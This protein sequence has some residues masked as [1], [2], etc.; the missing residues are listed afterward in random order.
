[1]ASVDS[2]TISGILKRRYSPDQVEN[3]Q[4]M[5]AVLWGKL[6]KGGRKITGNGL[7]F[8]VNLEGNQRGQ[9]S[10][11]EL[12]ALRTPASQSAQQGSVQNKIFTHH[13]QFSGLSL[14]IAKGD[15]ESFVDNM[16]F[17]IE[18]GFRDSAKELNA[19]CFRDGTGKLADVAGAVSADTTIT[20][21]GGVATHFRV[22]QYI[23]VILS[24]SK[25]ADSVKVTAVDIAN[26][27]ITVASAVTVSD[28]AVIYRE[29]TN[30]NAPS[31]GK[32]IAGLR[33]VVDNGT[34]LATYE[35]ISR[36]TYAK[37]DGLSIDASSANLSDDLLQRC[38]GRVQVESGRKPSKVIMN[39][40]G[41]FRK[42]LNILTPAKEYSVKDKMDSG[43]EKVPTWNGMEVIFD[44]DCG[45]G[46]VYMITPDLLERLDTFPLQL[47]EADGD[48]LKHK[49]GFDSY[50][51]VIK[52]YG[53]LMT[54]VPNAHIRLHNLATPTY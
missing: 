11:N 32:E 29:D 43:Y 28:N 2:S 47:D 41:Q 16:T 50:Y 46:E 26:S 3:L 23:D 21:D 25:E 48:V 13:L 31:D 10:Q 8:S 4:N 30:D 44:T 9:G 15:K 12:E 6:K 38:V 40:N 35:G 7:F 52:W 42:Y 24:G 22:G 53:N 20:F 1:M 51:A 5:D 33:L 37:W 45:F 17:Q 36:T 39:P 18:E 27:Q 19:Q 54:R 34:I 14:E 49:D